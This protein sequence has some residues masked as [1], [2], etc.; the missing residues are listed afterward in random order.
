[1]TAVDAVISP[2]AIPCVRMSG[3]NAPL[4]CV[5]PAA[6]ATATLTTTPT[7]VVRGDMGAPPSNSQRV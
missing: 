4:R 5:V 1:M 3:G 2:L 6:A 7:I